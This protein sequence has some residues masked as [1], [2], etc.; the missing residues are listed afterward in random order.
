MAERGDAPRRAST[1]LLLEGLDADVAGRPD[2]ALA[3][4]ERALQVDPTNPYAYL[5]V[6]RHELHAA[7]PER[8]LRFLDRA[9]AL[10]PEP[11]A[12]GARAH[13]L[14]MRG[15]ALRETGRAEEGLALLER[16]RRL[17]PEAWS[18][19][20]LDARELR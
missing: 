20:R 9:E 3:Q 12:P 17:A 1:R 8:A 6:A 18:D 7:R 2:A 19:A 15:A 14:G 5:A 13:L 4:Y 11:D 16:A 10:L